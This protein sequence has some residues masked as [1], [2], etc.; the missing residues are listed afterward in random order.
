MS[1]EER[2]CQSSGKT[3]EPNCELLKKQENV[4]KRG[5][6]TLQAQEFAFQAEL[7]GLGGGRFVIS[8][9]RNIYSALGL[10]HVTFTI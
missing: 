9:K 10:Y 8:R 6:V 5:T 1:R 2:F 4:R 3:T 7:C